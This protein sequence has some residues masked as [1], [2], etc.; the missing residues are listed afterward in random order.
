V[1][2]F[3]YMDIDIPASLIARAKA[4]NYSINDSFHAT[5]LLKLC[6]LYVVQYQH[7]HTKTIKGGDVATKKGRNS[8]K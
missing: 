7:T 5:S 6:V 1:E 4:V 2:F 8:R 3:W